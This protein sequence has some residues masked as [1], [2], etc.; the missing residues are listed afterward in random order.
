MGVSN[1]PSATSST[2]IP[3][4]HHNSTRDALIGDHVPRNSSA[5]AEDDAGNLG[6]SA[7]RWAIGYIKQIFVGSV[8][9][10]ISIESASGDCIVK[11]GG[12]ERARIPQSVGLL[13]AGMI[14]A[15]SGL[16]DPD[17]WLICDGREASR[18]TYARLYAAIA[19]TYGEGNGTTTFNLPDLRGQFLRGADNP[20]NGSGAA[21]IDPDAASRTA[22]DT[23]G[24][25]GATVGSIQV[26]RSRRI[27]DIETSGAAGGSVGTISPDDAGNFT[28]YIR[29]GQD[30]GGIYS[31]RAKTNAGEVRPI[32]AAVNFIIK[33]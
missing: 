26:D 25:T 30:G 9:D 24:N 13:P 14:V 8:A 10:N 12:T 2:V 7:Y 18:T 11:V 19:D 6:Q 5:N 1:I 23:G 29:T 22:M 21:G 31:M 17:E 4:A 33:T 16:S 20:G 32:N 27:S 28:G 3:A 15:Y